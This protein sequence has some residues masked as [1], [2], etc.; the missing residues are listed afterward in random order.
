MGIC[1]V[2]LRDSIAFSL[3]KQPAILKAPVKR[4]LLLD[5]NLDIVHIVEEV[6]SYEQYQVK[7]STKSAGFLDL[8]ENYQ[9]DLIILDYKL[10]DGNGGEICQTLKKEPRFQTIP[11]IIFT[12]YMEPGLDLTRY[13]CDAVISKPFDLQNLLDTV[14]DFLSAAQ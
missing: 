2:L 14:N 4:I 9:P 6:L 8:V 12:A 3:F 13:E 1:T 10:S 11:V 5:D 7:S